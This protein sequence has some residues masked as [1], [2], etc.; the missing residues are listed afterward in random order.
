MDF[1]ILFTQWTIGRNHNPPLNAPGAAKSML[2]GQDDQFFAGREIRQTYGTRGST[3]FPFRAQD[4]IGAR[5]Q[6]A[7]TTDPQVH[8]AD[9]VHNQRQHFFGP[10]LARVYMFSLAFDADGVFFGTQLPPFDVAP[11]QRVGF[12]GLRRRFFVHG[13]ENGEI[14]T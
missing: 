13:G 11:G 8:A 7:Q 12:G 5:K 3:D 4:S 2:T 14:R 1:T 10:N 9:V 6:T